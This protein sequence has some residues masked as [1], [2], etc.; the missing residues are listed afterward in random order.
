MSAPDMH[1]D[2]VMVLASVQSPVLTLQSHLGAHAGV[3]LTGVH[4]NQVWTRVVPAP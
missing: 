2:E 3:S 4:G 1:C